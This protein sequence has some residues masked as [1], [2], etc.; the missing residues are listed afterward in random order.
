MNAHPTLLSRPGDRT[1]FG[2]SYRQTQAQLFRRNVMIAA[3]VYVAFVCWDMIVAPMSVMIALKIRVLLVV[4]CVLLYLA[5]GLKSFERWYNYHFVAL[6]ASA[7]IGVAAILWF[8]PQGFAIG[9]GGVLLCITASSAIFRSSGWV[10]G[11]AGA[12]TTVATLVLMAWHGEPEELVRSNAIL[13]VTAVGFAMLHSVQAERTA[14]DVFR[15][16]E[17]LES[18]KA[19]TQALLR[20][21]TTMRQERLTWLESLARF[22]RHE[23]KNQIVAVGTSIDL[24]QNG[25]SLDA[26]RIYLDRAQQSLR[27]MRG[28]VSSATEATSLEAALEADE[29]E[30]VDWSA[31]VVDRVSTFQLLHPSRRLTMKLRPGLSLDGNEERLAQLLDKL[32][33]NATEHSRADAKIRVELQCMEAGWIELAVENEGDGLPEDKER[34]FEA[35]VS[36]QKTADNLGLGL[37]V[38][39]SI[40]HNQGGHIHAEDLPQGRGARFV[41]RLPESRPAH[42]DRLDDDSPAL[43]TT[44][45]LPEARAR[46]RD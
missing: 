41:V 33:S 30:R 19:R 1:A 22:L 38:A 35:F 20:D 8:V 31:V 27:R 25:D 10:T 23:L 29:T 44:P 21:I 7:G 2:A 39:Q 18:E 34:I 32:L 16:H 46:Q 15:A 28:L 12:V 45:P 43:P 9:I 6:I 42:R 37:F 26:N 14:Y 40:A 11:V 13:L 36:S 4:V 5:S 3:A 24:A 17:H